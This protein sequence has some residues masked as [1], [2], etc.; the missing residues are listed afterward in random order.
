MLTP[1]LYLLLSIV[2]WEAVE[3]RGVL[4]RYCSINNTMIEDT[5]NGARGFLLNWEFAVQVNMQHMYEMGGMVCLLLPL[6]IARLTVI[7]RVPYHFYLQAF[8]TSWQKL[9]AP[10]SP[11]PPG[12]VHPAR[13]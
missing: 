2:Q 11:H 5:E 12:K 6:L 1:N 4:H 13:A 10:W 8:S 7:Y 3:Q 9:L